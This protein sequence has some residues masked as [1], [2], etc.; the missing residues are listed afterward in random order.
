MINLQDRNTSSRTFYLLA[1]ARAG[2]D[3]ERVSLHWQPLPCH[4]PES[5]PYRHTHVNGVSWR[6]VAPDG[7]VERFGR[8]SR[9][10]RVTEFVGGEQIALPFG[11]DWNG[12][13]ETEYQSQR[14][15]AWNAHG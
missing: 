15:F 5:Q 13:D 1:L 12:E 10:A 4:D 2:V 8:I 3:W 9:A 7:I 11:Q 6:I 14:W